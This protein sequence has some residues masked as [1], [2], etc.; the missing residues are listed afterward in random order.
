M[1]CS[2]FSNKI[3]IYQYTTSADFMICHDSKLAFKSFS[4]LKAHLKIIL[5][6]GIYKLYDLHSRKWLNTSE[7]TR[8]RCCRD[9]RRKAGGGVPLGTGW[10]L[11]GCLAGYLALLLLGLNLLSLRLLLHALPLVSIRTSSTSAWTVVNSLCLSGHFR[12]WIKGG[13]VIYPAVGGTTTRYIQN[14]EKRSLRDKSR[15]IKR[16]VAY[17]QN[18]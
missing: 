9:S 17:V 7:N 3:E 16:G 10:Q 18:K 15:S 5:K 1:F 13:N 8:F 4:Q 11:G 2:C 6:G 12:S 14:A